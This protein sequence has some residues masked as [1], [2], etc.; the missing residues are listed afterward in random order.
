MI[1]LGKHC[2][3]MQAFQDP[4]VCSSTQRGFTLHYLLVFLLSVWQVKFA[5]SSKQERRERSQT[6]RKRKVWC[7]SPY[8]YSMGWKKGG[9][10]ERGISGMSVKCWL[11]FLG[12]LADG[13]STMRK[14][15]YGG[16]KSRGHTAVFHTYSHTA[17]F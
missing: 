1:C 7:S 14:K 4:P 2:N 11:R 17:D 13:C 15:I 16:G 10:E 12:N 3:V 6:R 8:S 5:S 9:E